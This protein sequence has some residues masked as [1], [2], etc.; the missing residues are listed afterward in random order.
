ML[1]EMAEALEVV[2]QERPL[3][4][5]FEDLHWSDPSTLDLSP[6]SHGAR[7]PRGS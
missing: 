3:V 1:R 4:L 7:S 5:V 6:P 2:T